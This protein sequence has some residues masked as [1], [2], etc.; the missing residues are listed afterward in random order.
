MNPIPLANQLACARRQVDR[1]RK[2]YA[3]RLRQGGSFNRHAA[4]AE[5]ANMEAICQTLEKLRDLEDVSEE[6]KAACLA[7]GQT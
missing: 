1:M 3:E 6:M 7:K 5:I 2:R 4:D